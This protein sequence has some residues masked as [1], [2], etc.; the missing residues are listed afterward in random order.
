M[1]KFT[2]ENY[3]EGLVSLN[4]FYSLGNVIND[5]KIN[6]C[7]TPDYYTL[8]FY[9][10][11]ES[12][13]INVEIVDDFGVFLLPPTTSNKWNVVLDTNQH[14]L[15]GFNVNTET[16][17]GFAN[18]PVSIDPLGIDSYVELNDITVFHS[19]LQ[20]YMDVQFKIYSENNYIKFSFDSVNYYVTYDKMITFGEVK[21]LINHLY[22]KSLYKTGIDKLYFEINPL[23]YQSE[24]SLNH[25]ISVEITNYCGGI[26][27]LNSPCIIR[28]REIGSEIGEIP[29][30]KKC[31]FHIYGG[32]RG[33]SLDVNIDK[34][35]LLLFDDKLFTN[36]DIIDVERLRDAP[37]YMNVVFT[38]DNNNPG[39]SF[40]I[41][42][43]DGR[44]GYTSVVLRMRFIEN[45]DINNIEVLLN[46]LLKKIDYDI[47]DRVLTDVIDCGD[48]K[49]VEFEISAAENDEDIIALDICED[50]LKRIND[51]TLKEP[52]IQNEYVLLN[53]SIIIRIIETQSPFDQMDDWHSITLGT[54]DCDAGKI[55]QGVCY[56]YWGMTGE[57]CNEP[58]ERK[59]INPCETGTEDCCEV[60]KSNLQFGSVRGGQIIS[61]NYNIDSYSVWVEHDCF[62]SSEGACIIFN[63]NG[64]PV[65][66]PNG[67]YIL[68]DNSKIY[69]LDKDFGNVKKIINNPCVEIYQSEDVKIHQ[70]IAYLGEE[71]GGGFVFTCQALPYRIYWSDSNFDMILDAFDIDDKEKI[72]EAIIPLEGIEY[73][74]TIVKEVKV[75]KV[76]T[77]LSTINIQEYDNVTGE[78]IEKCQIVNK[79]II[80]TTINYNIDD[81][82]DVLFPKLFIQ[83][84]YNTYTFHPA[85]N[86]KW[87]DV[88]FTVNGAN[89]ISYCKS[90]NLIYVADLTGKVYGL[91]PDGQLINDDIVYGKSD[92]TI[93]TITYMP[94]AGLFALYP[95]EGMSLPLI[96]DE[97]GFY[98]G[99]LGKELGSLSLSNDIWEKP[100]IYI[101]L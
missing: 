11:T 68:T 47:E 56:C 13:L 71:F 51:G 79:T 36:R 101:Y 43:T 26:R 23:N 84:Y 10:L 77:T 34:S 95:H 64:K 83:G 8:E 22:I 44:H 46:Q 29:K 24:I 92:D 41:L 45:T 90:K 1:I 54:T 70:N 61:Y 27:D 20:K 55:H 94:Y 53:N 21:K 38:G 4:S 62:T 86:I 59:C 31:E 89:D 3:F 60:I 28:D 14:S 67:D 100:G 82:E 52:I 69:V 15:I 63:R 40:K 12:T 78:L 32:R 93:S 19:N 42:V 66:L 5:D 33:I 81:N 48:R 7:L 6:L 17:Y 85:S 57:H 87:S 58:A 73:T 18:F 98:Y 25:Q 80:T 39:N 97:N 37:T 35:T 16:R 99:H 30:G 49:C 88:L 50:I 74:R 9:L 65:F 76:D 72:P 75:E 2:G 91:A 96:F